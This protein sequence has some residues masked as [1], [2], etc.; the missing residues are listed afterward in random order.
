MVEGLVARRSDLPAEVGL[1]TQHRHLRQHPPTTGDTHHQIDQHPVPI[2]HRGEPAAGHRPRQPPVNPVLSP[3]SR[4][5]ADPV[6][7]TTHARASVKLIR[8]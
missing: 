6:C 4:N 3:T 8:P 5:T 1:V 2:M 7:D